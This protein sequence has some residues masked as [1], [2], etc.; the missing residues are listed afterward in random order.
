MVSQETCNLGDGIVVTETVSFINCD[1]LH[2]SINNDIASG[3]DTAQINHQYNTILGAY[4]GTANCIFDFT[5]TDAS[6]SIVGTPQTIY[7][8]FGDAIV[9]GHYEISNANRTM[10][11][12]S[13]CLDGSYY[14]QKAS[15]WTVLPGGRLDKQDWDVV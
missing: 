3:T 8:D 6:A 13:S 2:I 1:E 10:N 15:I 4:R 7:S 14:K 12:A 11:F 9:G 5:F